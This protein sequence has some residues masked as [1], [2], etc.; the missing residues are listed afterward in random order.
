M[1]PTTLSAADKLAAEMQTVMATGS[2]GAL[3]GWFIVISL[4]GLILIMSA[5]KHWKWLQELVLTVYDAIKNSEGKYN[6]LLT[7]ATWS[8][9]EA[10][11]MAAFLQSAAVVTAASLL[12]FFLALAILAASR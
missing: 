6:E 5:I 8:Q 10:T 4:F 11:W 7:K 9:P 2:A 3:H 1:D 12:S